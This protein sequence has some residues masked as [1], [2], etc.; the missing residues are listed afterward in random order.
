MLLSGTTEANNNQRGQYS[1]AVLNEL[2]SQNDQQVEGILGKVKVLKDVCSSQFPLISIYKTNAP[3]PKKTDDNSH[4]RRNQRLVGPRGKDERGLRPDASPAPRH[5]E[6][7]A[8]HGGTDRRGLEGLAAVLCVCDI[9]V[10]V[11]VVVL[12]GGSASPREDTWG[13]ECFQPQSHCHS[14]RSGYLCYGC[15]HCRVNRRTE[16]KNGVFVFLFQCYIIF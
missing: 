11:C 16:R 14:F 13:I 15:L 12:I 5:H 1:D 7:D 4:R 10:H 6:Q 9:L 8:A 3:L 2:E